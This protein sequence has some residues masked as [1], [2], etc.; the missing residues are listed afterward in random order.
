M[1]YALNP[2]VTSL[3]RVLFGASVYGATTAGA[4]VIRVSIF[5]GHIVVSASVAAVF[6]DAAPLSPGFSR[7]PARRASRR[8]RGRAYGGPVSRKPLFA[9]G[10]ERSPGRDGFWWGRRRGAGRGPS[11]ARPG[12]REVPGR[13][14]ANAVLAFP[15]SASAG[16]GNVANLRAVD[17]FEVKAVVEA[18]VPAVVVA[19]GIGGVLDVRTVATGPA[20]SVQAR[21]L[22]PT[23]S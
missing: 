7:G 10:G 19:P 17:V 4:A 2:N 9:G 1:K 12:T 21:A 8:G 5:D 15:G 18:A 3:P 23:G 20:A 16:G 11:P 14:T 13:G 6:A 22:R